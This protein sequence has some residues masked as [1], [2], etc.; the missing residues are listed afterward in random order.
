LN[1]KDTG[2]EWIEKIPQDWK[3][4]KI[5]YSSYVKGRIGWQGLRSDDYTTE[6]PYLITGTEFINGKIDWKNCHHVDQSR[7]EQDPYIQVQNN[8][9]LITKDGTIGKVAIVEEMPGPATLNSGVLI[10]RPLNNLY[11]PEYMFWILQ[12]DIFTQY[13]EYSKT[14]T[15][16]NHLYQDT[17]ENFVF[18][19]PS[20]LKE[21]DIISRILDK[22]IEEINHQILKRFR[23]I[24]LLNEKIYALVNYVV[25][26]GLDI[27]KKRKDTG[28]EWIEKIPQDWKII[29]LKYL[30]QNRSKGIKIGPFGSSIK[31]EHL[32]DSGFKIYGQENIIKDNF[33]FGE[34][35][36]NQEKFDELKIFEILPNDVLITMMGSAGKSKV[37]PDGIE[38]GIMDSHL[39]R[40]RPKANMCNANFLSLLINSSYYVKAQIEMAFRGAVMDGLNSNI[41]K[42]ILICLP[43]VAEQE[44]IHQHV[45]N[46]IDQIENLIKKINLQIGKLDEYKQSLISSSIT[47]KIVEKITK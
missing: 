12:S 41:I 24:E 16:I 23:L 38:K 44:V 3:I 6:G 10:I 17:F 45:K 28:I 43:P 14:G 36:I 37:V 35:F 39:L 40:L 21:Q 34:R 18:V 31:L 29:P 26:K 5:K 25:T 47:G 30:L 27:S 13:I 42:S 22:K 4:H 9:I 19:T 7:Y 46:K 15:T 2:I 11:L 33:E 20:S 8:D 1:L 32:R